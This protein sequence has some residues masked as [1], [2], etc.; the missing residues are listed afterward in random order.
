[1]NDYQKV[2]INKRYKTKLRNKLKKFPN[3]FE[4]DDYNKKSINGIN[5]S[6]DRLMYILIT[7]GLGK[8]I[9]I[10]NEK[11]ISFT[12]LL[13]LSKESLKDFGLEMYQRNRIY[14]FATTFNRNAKTYSIKEITDFFNS[15]KQFLFSPSI[16]N[17]MIQLKKSQNFESE[18][19]N[20]I[21]DIKYFSD[22]E[23][24][25]YNK[26]K[27]NSKNIDNILKNNNNKFGSGK[28]TYKASKIFK[29]YLLLKKGVDEF[30]N[31]INKQKEDT[32]NMSYKYNAFFKRI[33]NLND[34]NST[35][36]IFN[37]YNIND[38]NE[39]ILNLFEDKNMNI[40]SNNENNKN[41]EY[42]KLIDK[43]N[44]LEQIKIDENSYEHLNQIKKYINEK[45]LNL[46]IDEIISLQNE[47]EK[48][49]E[50][51]NKK[52]QLKK[53]LE[54]YNKKIEQRKKMIFKLEND[55]NGVYLENNEDK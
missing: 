53:D 30:L 1:M 15:N 49:T 39:E 32:E 47:L 13:L 38:D 17:K 28:K 37:N 11:N 2:F 5:N 45:G 50:I 23:S 43:I 33:N 52:K 19:G 55:Y 16:Y 29:K 21:N 48:I 40:N 24:N 27:K 6:D 35:K 51:I 54:K 18:W 14:N 26:L 8:L 9:Y 4:N 7:L 12:D 10:F 22:N 42:S 31:K 34:N 41:D 3:E 46:K 25:N 36:K 20:N 44:K